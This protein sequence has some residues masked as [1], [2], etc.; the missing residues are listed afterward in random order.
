MRRVAVVIASLWLT[1]FGI[2]AVQAHAELVSMT[3]APGSVV[4]SSPAAVSLT[5]GEDV[6]SIGST[7]VVLDPNGNA[8]QMGEPTVAGATIA[9]ELQPLT[10]AGTYHVN[11]R[12]MSKDGHIVNDF[13]TF[14]FAPSNGSAEPLVIATQS[15]YP[16]NSAVTPSPETSAVTTNSA[17][18]GFWIAAFL[19]ACGLLVGFAIWRVKRV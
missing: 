10:T 19:V 6:T 18:I 2:S 13:E 12:V 1:G 14:E 4:T 11:F 5:F 16:E 15:Q 8:M 9:V 7:I 17:T 3:P